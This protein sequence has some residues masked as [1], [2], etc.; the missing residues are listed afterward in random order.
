MALST[1]VIMKEYW[2]LTK[3]HPTKCSKC[4]GVGKGDKGGYWEV[5]VHYFLIFDFKAVDTFSHVMIYGVTTL[6]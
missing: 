2:I 6:R 1:Y 5:Y 3:G 4:L